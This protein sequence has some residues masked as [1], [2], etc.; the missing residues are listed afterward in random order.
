MILEQ[1]HSKLER[2]N[3]TL[4]NHVVF[5]VGLCFVLS[6]FFIKPLDWR[7][8]CISVGCSLVASSIASFLT[9]RYLI[10]ISRIKNIVEYWGLE[11]IY[12]TRQEMNQ[13][14]NNA[15]VNLENN[16]DI[17]AL[18]LKSFRDA[19][20]SL[21]KAKV[22]SGL[23]VRIIA[24]HPDSAY[25]VQREH[26]EKEVP[27]Q[28]RQTILHLGSWIDELKSMS[29]D[30]AN[31]QIKY[32]NSLPEDFYFKVDD[33]IFIGP[34]RYGISSQ[35]TIS[36]EFKGPSNGFRDYNLHFAYFF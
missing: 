23:K 27:G 31:V 3:A 18:G 9:S 13:S 20:D 25:V 26:D 28:I 35:Q 19:K 16:L 10:R 34:Y 11:S 33:F 5:W 7:N 21:V 1:I 22:Q 14:T 6:G 2:T 30:A 32:Y 15:F 24:P 8:V 4:I 12:Q 29:P 36:Y 17:I